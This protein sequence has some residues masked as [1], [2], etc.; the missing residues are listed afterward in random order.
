MR[1]KCDLLKDAKHEIDEEA[2]DADS[3]GEEYCERQN[4]Y[5]KTQIIDGYSTLDVT[6]GIHEPF[7]THYAW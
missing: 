6:V 1:S 5:L 4:H 2:Y 3:D 7:E